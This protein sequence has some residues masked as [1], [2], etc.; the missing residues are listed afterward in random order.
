[1]EIKALISVKTL[2]K[3]IKS[4]DMMAHAFNPALDRGHRQVDLC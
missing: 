3:N 2:H 4:L 1:M